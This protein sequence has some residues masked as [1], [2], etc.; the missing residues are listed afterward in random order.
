MA[1]AALVAAVGRAAFRAPVGVRDPA[2]EVAYRTV[3]RAPGVRWLLAV[4]AL[5][6]LACY[7]QYDSG[8]PAYALT[9]LDVDP[10]TLGSAVALNA[11]LVGVL[12]APVLRL[13]RTTAPARLLAACGVVWIGVWAVLAL[14]LALPAAAGGLVVT[15][16]A[17]FSLG[18]TVLAPVLSPLAASLAPPGAVGRTLAA[19]NGAQTGA[20]ALGPGLS[21]VL[22]AAGVPLGFI[23]LQLACCLLAV[24]GA[25][26]LAR[27]AASVVPAPATARSGA[28]GR[29]GTARD[30]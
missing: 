6:T 17:L 7:A 24:A 8:L 16:Y 15:G 2:E 5:L 25:G 28:T 30:G 9:V 19:M 1:S 26:R 29:R 11:V 18:E 10:A 27:P 14:P 12:T 20:T 4:T 23:A 13:T 22:L 21:G 3:L